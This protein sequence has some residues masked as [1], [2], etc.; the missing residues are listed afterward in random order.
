MCKYYQVGRFSELGS[1]EFDEKSAFYHLEQAAE[2][3][4][5]EAIFALAKIYLDLPRDLLPDYQSKVRFR[6]FLTLFVVE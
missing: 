3:S 2:L 1:E 4:V 5:K 6:M